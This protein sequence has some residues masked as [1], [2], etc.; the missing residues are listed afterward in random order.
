ML[1]LSGAA[2]NAGSSY[3]NKTWTIIVMVVALAYASFTFLITGANETVGLT[4]KQL[5]AAF[6]VFVICLCLVG[7]ALSPNKNAELEAEI[8]QMI[9]QS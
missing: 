6:A 4:K 7:M 5:D 1:K 8:E 3:L 2:K 9:R